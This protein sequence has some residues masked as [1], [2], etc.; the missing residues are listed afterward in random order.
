MRISVWQGASSVTVDDVTNAEHPALIQMAGLTCQ[1]GDEK[2]LRDLHACLDF[3][4][5]RSG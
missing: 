5:G 2:D 3:I 4:F 1:T